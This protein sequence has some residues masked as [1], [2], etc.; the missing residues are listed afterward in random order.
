MPAPVASFGHTL[1]L[2]AI[3]AAAFAAAFALQTG[4]GAPT[5]AIGGPAPA[6]HILPGLI[7]SLAFDWGILY[8]VW[9]GVRDRGGSLLQLSGRAWASRR[10]V[11]RDL[12]IAAPFWVL[13]QATAWAAFT[14]LNHFFAPEAAPADDSFPVRGALEIATWITV[15]LSAGFCEEL[16]FAAIC[17]ASSPPSPAASGS[18]SSCKG[19]CS[20]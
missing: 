17:S 16:I 18:A 1:G 15:S 13:W 19:R 10:D 5:A 4:P 6:R 12:L 11:A 7:E 14:A 9:G 20:A 8:Y 3:F 2:A